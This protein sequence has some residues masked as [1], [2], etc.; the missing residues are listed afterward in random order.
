[1]Q[2][3]HRA[4]HHE[5]RDWME[6]GTDRVHQHLQAIWSR[7]DHSQILF[8][9][10]ACF[11]A[12]PNQTAYNAKLARDPFFR[13]D[14]DDVHWMIVYS[15]CNRHYL[16]H[17]DFLWRVVDINVPIQGIGDNLVHAT[18]EGLFLGY[19]LLQDP[20]SDSSSW[21]EFS[22]FGMYVE[23]G[24]VSLFSI[25]QATMTGENTVVHEG[26]PDSGKHGIYTLS[27]NFIPFHFCYETQLWWIPVLRCKDENTTCFNAEASIYDDRRKS[28]TLALTGVGDAWHSRH[29]ANRAA[30]SE[31][32]RHD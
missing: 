3:Q 29:S 9:Q 2:G 32:P 24:A 11:P 4:H 19:F 17:L 6:D 31:S 14:D 21:A 22:S 8:L 23:N 25:S 16:C 1:M 20:D 26:K 15:G 7:A 5:I 12:R 30:D 28:D 27:W 13:R 18:K 10:L